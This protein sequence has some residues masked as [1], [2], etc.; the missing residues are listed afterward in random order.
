MKF[1]ALALDYDGTIA[2]DGVLDQAVRESIAYVR[3]KGIV[4][5]L[6]TGRILSELRQVAGD[7]HFVDAIVAENG[8]AL[9]FTD[10]GYSRLLGS[11]PAP[12]LL[13]ELRRRN[14]RASCG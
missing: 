11:P 5:L 7:L 2:A 9:E 14:I 12:E 8:A 13:Q 4:V 1:L 10:S 6:V 3:S